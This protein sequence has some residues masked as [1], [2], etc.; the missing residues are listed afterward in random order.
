[1][2]KQ[3]KDC[4]TA[5]DIE[6]RLENSCKQGSIQEQTNISC[7]DQG[8]QPHVYAPCTNETKEQ[9]LTTC[10]SKYLLVSLSGTASTAK[11]D[12]QELTTS[13]THEGSQQ[14]L[15]ACSTD[16]VGQESE[17]R[18]WCSDHGLERELNK[19]STDHVVGPQVDTHAGYLNPEAAEFTPASQAKATDPVL[20]TG[21]FYCMEKERST[22]TSSTGQNTLPC[23]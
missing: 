23:R 19:S 14:E 7:I 6:T 13:S 11:V 12:K 9:D 16:E 20:L 21:D 10:S 4:S 22:N 2:E 1:M 18:K 8:L 3:V 5:P 15:S 17:V